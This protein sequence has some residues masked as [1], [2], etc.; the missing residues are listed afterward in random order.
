MSN[1]Q[2]I[3]AVFGSIYLFGLT[4]ILIMMRIEHNQKK[5]AGAEPEFRRE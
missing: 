5:R 4:G 1:Q 3:F 2:F